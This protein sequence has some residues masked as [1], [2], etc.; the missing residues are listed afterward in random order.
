MESEARSPKAERLTVSTFWYAIFQG[1]CIHLVYSVMQDQH[2]NGRH[3]PLQSPKPV[4]PTT[5]DGV[6]VYQK[7]TIQKNEWR[8]LIGMYDPH[9][10]TAAPQGTEWTK[11]TVQEIWY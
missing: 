8:E 2:V 6:A 3:L 1:F 10:H 4:L 5:K 9:V 7:H 11:M